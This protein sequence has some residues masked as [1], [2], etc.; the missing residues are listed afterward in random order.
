LIVD[1]HVHIGTTLHHFKEISVTADD[2][3]REMDANGVEMAVLCPAGAE[4]AVHNRAGNDLVAAAVKAYPDRFLGLATA[5]PWYGEDA[6]V[7]LDR[8]ITDLGL[9]GFKFHSLVQGFHLNDPLLVYPLVEKA[10]DLDVPVYFH[11]GTPIMALPYKLQDLV[12]RYP[13]ARLI[14]GH[15]GWDFH[16]DVI[17]VEQNCPGLWL[18][19]SKCEYVNLEHSYRMG[20]A[21]RLI[22]GSDYPISSM[23]SELSKVRRLLGLTSVHESAILGRNCLRLFGLE[24]DA[25]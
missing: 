14:M 24:E 16:F 8:A 10:I 17:Y 18:E 7:E 1:A 19:T 6:L 25:G 5:N 4:L 13:Q 20:N 21:G 11:C 12:R 23:A 9:S 15:R 22:F 3:L 2:I